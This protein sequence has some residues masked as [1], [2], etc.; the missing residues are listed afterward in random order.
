M[1]YKYIIQ[2]YSNEKIS[3][4]LFFQE[5]PHILGQCF[6][7]IQQQIEQDFFVKS[8]QKKAKAKR[9]QRSCAC[10]AINLVTVCNR[11]LNTSF[12]DKAQIFYYY[13]YKKQYLDRGTYVYLYTGYSICMGQ[14]FKEVDSVASFLVPGISSLNIFTVEKFLDLNNEITTDI[15]VPLK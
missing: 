11:K 14:I 7:G 13:F 3:Q 10:Q 5:W 15:S 4:V 8:Q 1:K 9:I 12:N 2:N 6:F